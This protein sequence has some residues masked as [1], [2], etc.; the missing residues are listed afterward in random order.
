MLLVKEPKSH[1][2]ISVFQYRKWKATVAAEN[3]RKSL[4]SL[5]FF[6]LSQSLEIRFSGIGNVILEIA[7]IRN[8]HDFTLFFR[9]KYCFAIR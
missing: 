2:F 8:N 7:K 5:L 3:K 6:G 1:L 4:I 9:M